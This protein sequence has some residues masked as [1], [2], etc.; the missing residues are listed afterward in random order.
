MF[1]AGWSLGGRYR[2]L[3]G[4]AGVGLYKEENFWANEK[5]LKIPDIF[6]HVTY[7]GNLIYPPHLPAFGE[8]KGHIN[9]VVH[10][11]LKHGSYTYR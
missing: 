8:Q 2:H 11:F 1:V 5:S 6:F 10:S 9:V 4:P 7:S 3:T